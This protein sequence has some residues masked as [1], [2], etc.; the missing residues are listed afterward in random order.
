MIHIGLIATIPP[1]PALINE[2]IKQRGMISISVNEVG[3]MEAV[4]RS[5][6]IAGKH[7]IAKAEAQFSKVTEGH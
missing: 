2:M 6:V 7:E 1:N 3:K 5:R 4:F